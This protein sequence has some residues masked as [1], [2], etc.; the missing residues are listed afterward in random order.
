MTD[1]SHPSPSME[2]DSEFQKR[3][4]E[5][6]GSGLSAIIY[7]RDGRVAKVY[8]EGQPRRQVFQ[9]AFTL[10]TVEEQ[11]IPVPKV[12]GVETFLGRTT[13]I[14]EQVQGESLADMMLR[15]P[16]KTSECLDKVV[17]LQVAMH[18][19]SSANF[20]PI[21][22]VLAGNIYGAPQLDDAERKKLLAMLEQFPDGFAI[23]HGDF[24]GGNILFDGK[25][26][27]IIDW[28]EVAVGDPAAD[29]ARSY[30]DY[31]LI[32]KKDLSEMYLQKYCAATGIPRDKILAWLPVI[33]G[34]LYGFMSPSMQKILRPLF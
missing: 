27:K 19:V 34:S 33:A 5:Q 20:R 21:K 1:S 26:Y 14:M 23:L 2:N 3:Y 7:A 12:Y 32:D 25:G 13:L 4:G 11:G 24:H 8:R 29:V 31:L 30:M 10:V 18:K 17:E 22:L 16:E 15:L 9:E 6:I 28:A